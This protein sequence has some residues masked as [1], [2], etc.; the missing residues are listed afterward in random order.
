MGRANH[1]CSSVDVERYGDDYAIAFKLPS[2]ST[3]RKSGIKELY[4][5]EPFE[6][7]IL[8]DSDGITR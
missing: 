8:P 3:L 1:A 5:S 6:D 4:V 7:D 2:G